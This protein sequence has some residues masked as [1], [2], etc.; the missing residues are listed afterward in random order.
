MT[1]ARLIA[2]ALSAVVACAVSA[3]LITQHRS[4]ARLKSANATLR[5]QSKHLA[6]VCTSFR[7]TWSEAVAAGLSH[8]VETVTV[9]CSKDQGPLTHCASG[10]LY[11]FSADGSAPPDDAV[12]PLNVRFHR[13]R[14]EDTIAQAP[15]LKVLGVQQ[16]VVLSDAWGY[17]GPYPGD[18]GDWAKWEQFVLRQ[19][20]LLREA[21]VQ[22]QYDV[23]NE[24][25]HGYFWRRTPEQFLE[26]WT[27][28]CRVLRRAD[29]SAVIVGPSWS[30]VRPGDGRFNA[31]LLH[32][33]TNGAAPDYVSWHFPKDA[34]AECRACRE[35]CAKHTIPIR[36]VWIN[37]YCCANEQ[38]A[39]NTAFELAELEH[40]G[41]NGACHAIWT[42]DG[43]HDRLD[44][45]LAEDGRP[46]GPWWLYR[47][48]AAMSGRILASTPTDHVQA[49]AAA[50]S[51]ARKLD[52]LLGRR[53][54][55][56][57]R[58]VLR[59]DHLDALSF[60]GGGPS[61]QVKVERVPDGAGAAVA[62]LPVTLEGTAARMQG[63]LELLLPWLD[64]AEA[65]VVQISPRGSA[66]ATA[67]PPFLNAA[68]GLGVR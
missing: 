12:L 10:F 38:S 60:L 2:V 45:I 23:W 9:D 65:Y 48:Y 49:V 50:D 42:T 54:G 37:E 13:T 15:R 36:G 30:N 11:G 46:R 68:A 34:V 61:V 62:A 17:E 33:L 56:G 22:A 27:R 53:G 63:Q 40:A 1:S 16:Q 8:R 52:I 59:L 44:G 51:A 7:E 67:P 66:L 24:P 6:Q 28:A 4:E 3:T 43:R 19:V 25:D 20:D 35:F 21:G 32:C 57:L 5:A 29:P 41:V 14:I 39:A 31:F 18:H 58:V 26:T 55:S 47:R 64:P